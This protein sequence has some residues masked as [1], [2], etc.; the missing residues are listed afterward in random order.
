MGKLD[1]ID[2]I[3]SL[4]NNLFILC[5]DI[6]LNTRLKISNSTFKMKWSINVINI[7]F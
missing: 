2:K 5:V 4:N 6:V 3:D 7:Y 1:F